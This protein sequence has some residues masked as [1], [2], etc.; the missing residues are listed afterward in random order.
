MRPVGN[1]DTIGK[2]SEILRVRYTEQSEK[3]F[4]DYLP[5]GT[6]SFFGVIIPFFLKVER[7]SRLL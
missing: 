2:L 3:I 4:E 7:L 5:A 6:L 1:P